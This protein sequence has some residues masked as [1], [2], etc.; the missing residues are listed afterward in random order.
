[1]TATHRTMAERDLEVHP[2]HVNQQQLCDIYIY[3][4]FTIHFAL[5]LMF[6]P[7]V[8]PNSHVHY[9]RSSHYET[10]RASQ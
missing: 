3:T 9:A 4:F 7:F 8:S 1:M 10:F 6:A 2:T 5:F